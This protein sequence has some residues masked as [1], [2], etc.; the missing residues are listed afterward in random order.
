MEKKEYAYLGM[1]LKMDLL[2][3]KFAPAILDSNG[4]TFLK[5]TAGLSD[6]NN[7]QI[8][9]IRKTLP[10]WIVRVNEK[11]GVLIKSYKFKGT[12]WNKNR[13]R[14]EWEVTFNFEI[15]GALN[16]N[17]VHPIM[18]KEFPGF[19]KKLLGAELFCRFPFPFSPYEIGKRIPFCAGVTDMYVLKPCNGGTVEAVKKATD[20]LFDEEFKLWL[21]NILEKK[22]AK[23]VSIKSIPMS[24]KHTEFWF[25]SIILMRWKKDVNYEERADLQREIEKKMK[26]KKVTRMFSGSEGLFFDVTFES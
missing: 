12:R 1:P 14:K 7:G 10:E 18:R 16:L 20:L 2:L 25:C 26:E 13:R 24:S 22:S 9:W 8:A 19:F 15:P 5:W 3:K 11:S 17:S 23:L 21:E 4:K 6:Q